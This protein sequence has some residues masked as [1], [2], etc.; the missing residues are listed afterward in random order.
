MLQLWLS[1]KR[2][3]EK[4]T[5]TRHLWLNYTNIFYV[6]IF[7]SNAK[8]AYL[9]IIDYTILLNSCL[10]WY[11]PIFVDVSYI[12]YCPN[13][14]TN[15]NQCH[16]GAWKLKLKTIS[17]VRNYAIYQLSTFLNEQVPVHLFWISQSQLLIGNLQLFCILDT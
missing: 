14:K 15:T 10:I 3:Y 6:K 5:A 8:Q 12:C 9:E 11:L 13:Y 1:F 2:L 16:Y 4:W 17:W 7:H